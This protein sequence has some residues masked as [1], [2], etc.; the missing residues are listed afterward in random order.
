MA[1]SLFFVEF[2]PLL[3]VTGLLDM[4]LDWAAVVVLAKKAELL[5]VSS[6]LLFWGWEMYAALV[7]YYC[8]VLL[9]LLEEFDPRWCVE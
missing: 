5:P 1:S 9:F 2:A 4:D 7:P 6:L 3:T 8:A